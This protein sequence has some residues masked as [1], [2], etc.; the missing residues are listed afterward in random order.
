MCQ[1][2]GGRGASF[3]IRQKMSIYHE[4]RQGSIHKCRASP[5]S[6]ATSPNV[7]LS[8]KFKRR[9]QRKMYIQ[10]FDCSPGVEPDK[11]KFWTGRHRRS[12]PSRRCWPGLGNVDHL[13]FTTRNSCS[14][15]PKLNLPLVRRVYAADMYGTK[16]DMKELGMLSTVPSFLT[17]TFAPSL[18]P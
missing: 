4:T 13:S 3:S 16:H 14:A 10:K 7:K 15:A 17:A 11:G 2:D 6:N 5:T 12:L 8:E 9:Q 18:L 1:H